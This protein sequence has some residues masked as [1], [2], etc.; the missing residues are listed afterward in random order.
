MGL[1]PL[2]SEFAIQLLEE[3]KSFNPLN[4]I[5][6][7]RRVELPFL[8][9]SPIS[10]IEAQISPRSVLATR[11]S[12]EPSEAEYFMYVYMT[13]RGFERIGNLGDDNMI[14]RKLN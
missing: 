7:I 10:E 1:F 9:I 6:W 13:S 3:F 5:K 4:I 8:E 14:I 11:F 2:S 12:V